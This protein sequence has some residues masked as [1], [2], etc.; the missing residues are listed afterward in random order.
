MIVR[1]PDYYESF[2][3]LAGD[4]PHS[5]CEKWEVVIDPET[6]ERYRQVEGCLGEEL[7]A[8]LREDEDGDLCFALQGGRCPF[9][10]QENL[11]RIHL[12]LGEAA[13]SITCREHPRFTE[14]YGP[15]RE[16][17]L[18]ASCPAANQ[19]LLGSSEPLRF[20]E[21][22]TEEPQEEGDAWLENLVWLREALLE[23]LTD[24]R[25]PMR[26]RLAEFLLLAREAQMWLD[27]D[28]IEEIPILAEGW[29]TLGPEEP[30]PDSALFP[31]A[32]HCLEEAE[33]LEP[34]WPAMLR[35]AAQ[36]QTVPLP[37]SLLERMAVYFGFRYLLKSVN[38]GL[39]LPR[40]QWVV[41][42]VLVTERLAAVCGPE[43]ALRR[44]SC[45]MEHSDDNLEMLLEWMETEPC[46]SVQSF[47]C[48]L[49]E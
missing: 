9:L 34:D 33:V 18:A 48:A 22:Q 10:N 8:V 16:I 40:A 46:L 6:A 43:E 35:A 27:Q 24:R 45:E 30:V 5:C 11:C 20:M 47:L 23:R 17:N 7:R 19:L 39:L 15:F 4:C 29:R 41:F 38:D 31:Q 36:V 26:Q 49:R 1:A 42:A 28:R 44:L 14:D 13:T 3:C 12:E 21:W 2:R 32:L 37:D 25:I